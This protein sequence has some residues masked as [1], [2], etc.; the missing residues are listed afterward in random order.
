MASQAACQSDAQTIEAAEDN[1]STLNGA[2]ATMDEL[3]TQQL[4]RTASIYYPEIIVG[5]PA[6]GY[7]LVATTQKC[8]NL[9]LPVMGPG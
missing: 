3:V 9:R 7:T 6:G 1:Y 5:A 4:L 2:F 8:E